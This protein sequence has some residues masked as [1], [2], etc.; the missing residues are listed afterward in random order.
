MITKT[1][2]ILLTITFLCYS[3][4]TYARPKYTP[5]SDSGISKTSVEIS[6]NPDG[7]TIE[8]QNVKNR[9]LMDNQVGSIKHLYIISPQTGNVLLYSTVKGKVTSSN[10]RL[11][12]RT[13]STN[14]DV[15]DENEGFLVTIGSKNKRTAEVLQ[16][17]GT[18]GDS[19]PYIFWWDTKG[20]YH[21]HFLTDGQI[22]HVSD[23]PLRINPTQIKLNL[24]KP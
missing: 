20:I 4:T 22:I 2:Y 10:K 7:L 24:V 5:K 17:D 16:D 15:Y 14:S 18:Y 12:P 3:C 13:V 23:Q 19:D 9:L 21:Q 11:T 1:K 8:Q 6:T